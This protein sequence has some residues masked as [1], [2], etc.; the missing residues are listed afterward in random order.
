MIEQPP[1]SIIVEVE[2][3][4]ELEFPDGTDPA[5]IQQTVQKLTKDKRIDDFINEPGPLGQL[6]RGAAQGGIMS[7]GP[8]IVDGT[9]RVITGIAKRMYQGA[10]KPTKA[11]VSRT[12][13]GEAALAET[14]L[15]EGLTVS[16]GGVQKATDL[17]EGL[18][19]QVSSAIGGSSATVPQQGVM[20]RL[21]TPVSQ[22]KDQ[23]APLGDLKRIAN[24]GREFKATTPRDIPVQQAQKIKQGTY[25]AQ[26]KKYGQ[27]GGAEVEAEKALARGLKEEIS[28]A[29]PAVA[30]LNARQ[31]Q[32]IQI[33]KA[34]D[35]ATRRGGNR[36]TVGLTD[37]VAMGTNPKLLA[38]TLAMRAAPQSLGARALYRTG[39]AGPTPEALQAAIRAL[40]ASQGQD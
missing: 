29:V 18:D 12:P 11:V 25:K 40:I 26:A 33:R 15:K 38:T 36:D 17:I 8:Q 27:Q 5:V 31:S 13:G 24:V 35:D 16:R 2:G 28:G 4:G 21:A 14:G 30:P 7:A 34:L 3:I 22:F 37:V 9:R 19:D 20:R 39:Q 6:T 10:L 23:V 1:E 32:I